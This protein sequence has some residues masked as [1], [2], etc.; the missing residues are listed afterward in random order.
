MVAYNYCLSICILALCWTGNLKVQ[1]VTPLSLMMVK[2][3]NILILIKPVKG[4]ILKHV[5]CEILYTYIYNVSFFCY[6]IDAN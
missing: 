6:F 4:P 2:F 5:H 1:S 3:R